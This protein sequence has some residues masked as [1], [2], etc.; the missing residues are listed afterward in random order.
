VIP[1]NTGTLLP[2]RERFVDSAADETLHWLMGDIVSPDMLFARSSPTTTGERKG[3]WYV[4]CTRAR[5]LLIIPEF[6][7]AE[8][9]S[10]APPN[11]SQARISD[12]FFTDGAG[13]C[14]DDLHGQTQQLF[15]GWDLQRR[16]ELSANSIR[17][18]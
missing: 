12:G 16:E 2:S 5:Q 3:L 17:P 8:Q 14:R 9:P 18:I 1:I 11:K 4:V 6:P 15:A 7:Q 10:W 13:Q